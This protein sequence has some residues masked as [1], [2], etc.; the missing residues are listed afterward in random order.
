MKLFSYFRSSASYRV[1]IA[2]ELK[3]LK[4]DVL[5]I[6]LLKNGGEQLGLEYQKLNPEGLVPA[7]LDSENGKDSAISQSL[8]I[9]EFLDEKFPHSPLLPQN[10]SD[11]AYVRSLSLAIACDIHPL[12]NLRVLKYLSG[13]LNIQDDQKTKWIQH[14]CAVGLQAFEKRLASDRRAGDFCFGNSPTMADCVL[15]PQIFNAKRFN[16]DLSGL[17][18]LMRIDHNCQQLDAFIRAAPRN[19]IDAEN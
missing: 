15:I 8:A 14:W 6:H 10:I 18:N 2:L 3:N 19:Q 12:N 13:T 17:P 16:C 11:R 5:P 1:R 7:L 4:Y 9:I